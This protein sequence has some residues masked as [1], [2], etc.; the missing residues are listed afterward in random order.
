MVS[1]NLQFS[2]SVFASSFCW[3]SLELWT[4]LWTGSSGSP[5]PRSSRLWNDRLPV[6]PRLDSWRWKTIPQLPRCRKCSW[7][8]SSSPLPDAT[9][10]TFR[11]VYNFPFCCT[12]FRSAQIRHHPSTVCRV[13]PGWK[14]QEV[15]LVA[16]DDR[17]ARRTYSENRRKYHWNY[18]KIAKCPLIKSVIILSH[19]GTH[20]QFYIYI[21]LYNYTE[22]NH[23]NHA[24]IILS[25]MLGYLTRNYITAIV[26]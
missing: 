4:D 22:K 25:H 13:S 26:S 9:E 18:F 24:M 3:T 6:S 14:V 10:E 12:S 15:P 11:R 20:T 8:R 17:G 16:S 1:K 19:I 5:L 21:S 7:I 23:E 2:T